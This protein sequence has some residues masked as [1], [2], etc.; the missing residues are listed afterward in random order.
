MKKCLQC[1]FFVVLFIVFIGCDTENNSHNDLPPKTITEWGIDGFFQV[2]T[3]EDIHLNDIYQ[4]TFINE[5]VNSNIFQ[6]DTK[7]I[8]GA[9]N[10]AYGMMFAATIDR[11]TYHFINITV[12]G[13]YL[14]GKRINGSYTMIQD[15]TDS[16]RMLIGF[17]SINTIRVSIIG[18]EF[19]LFING[20]PHG[21][22]PFDS[23]IRGNRIGFSVS[24]GSS[25][26]ESFPNNP[27]DVKFKQTN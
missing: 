7:K 8:S 4:I 13:Y 11:E 15:W 25:E 24:I 21:T 22:F 27:V 26:Q 2:Y 14:I 10:R 18:S 6:I 19:N 1:I 20:F 9:R 23:S 17:N 5:N 16:I 12:D 3:N